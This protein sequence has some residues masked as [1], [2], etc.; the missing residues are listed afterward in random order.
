MKK[1]ISSFFIAFLCVAVAFAQTDGRRR[2][3][4]TVIADG[5]AQLPAKNTGK[6]YQIIGEM[7]STGEQ[8]VLQVAGNLKPYGTGAK[9]SV[10]EYALSGIT[11]YAASPD[12]AKCREGVRSGLLKAVE[13]CKDATNKTFLMNLLARVATPADVAVF[14]K[15]LGDDIQRIPALSAITS[16]NG[17][18]AEALDIVKNS[19][20]VPKYSLAKIVEAR[21][22]KGVENL[23]VKWSDDSDPKTRIAVYDAMAAVGGEETFEILADAAKSTS[24]TPE[25]THALDA[26]LKA[27]D[28]CKDNK[29]VT[30]AAKA[31][32]KS[33][34]PAVRCAGLRLMLKTAGS[35]TTKLATAALKDKDIQYRNTALECAGQYADKDIFAAVASSYK[36]LS[37]AAK[38]DVVRW[39]GNNN[40]KAQENILIDAIASGDSALSCA[41]M[42]AV[43]KLGGS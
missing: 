17:A 31:L 22:L 38:T 41:G 19:T 14:A 29:I 4:S 34:V 15:Y 32:T 10:F 2:T 5:L 13:N 24:F 3:A 21:K 12:G 16:I 27:L 40:A 25:A 36:K 23:L 18:D 39:L 1:I 28:R 26:Y 20:N 7:A 35:K 37:P 43:A 33:D 11:D 42:Q 9:N 8:G 6:F 30:K